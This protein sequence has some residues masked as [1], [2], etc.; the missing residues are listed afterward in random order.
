MKGDYGKEIH[1]CGVSGHP[2]AKGDTQGFG[3]VEDC[4]CEGG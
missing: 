4:A 2:G 1:S 3:G